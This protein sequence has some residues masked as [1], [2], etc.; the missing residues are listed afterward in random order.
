MTTT[1]A[2]A[3]AVVVRALVAVYVESNCIQIGSDW[4]RRRRG[5]ETR[6]VILVL[7]VNELVV[8]GVVEKGGF[9]LRLFEQNRVDRRRVTAAEA[10]ELGETVDSRGRLIV[11]GRGRGR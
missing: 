8:A 11:V 5:F 9:A 6:L 2:A 7:I 3:A 4:R 10:D 1:T